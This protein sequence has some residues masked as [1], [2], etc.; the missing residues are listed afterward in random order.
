[1]RNIK[2]LHRHKKIRIDCHGERCFYKPDATAVAILEKDLPRWVSVR[3]K[4]QI[5]ESL[6]GLS[7]QM[8]VEVV[9]CVN[10]CARFGRCDFTEIRHID[11]LLTHHYNALLNEADQLGIAIV[12]PEKEYEDDLPW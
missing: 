9:A 11:R 7:E 3:L 1:M 6:R 2:F 4:N 10:N 12:N 8:A 5:I